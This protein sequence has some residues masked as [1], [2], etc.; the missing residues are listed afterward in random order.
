MDF[1]S[2]LIDI[3]MGFLP[4][5]IEIRMLLDSE[6]FFLFPLTLH[7]FCI[8]LLKTEIKSIDNYNCYNKIFNNETALI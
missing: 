5:L 1:L 4:I 8:K 2:I 7:R 3:S 6:L